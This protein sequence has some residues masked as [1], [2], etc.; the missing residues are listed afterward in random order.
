[1]ILT[2]SRSAT[3]GY[4]APVVKISPHLHA[5]FVEAPSSAQIVTVLWRYTDC[6]FLWSRPQRGRLAASSRGSALLEAFMSTASLSDTDVRVR[7]AV[8]RQLDWDPEVDAGAVGVSAK[9]GAVTLTGYIDTYAGKLAAERAAKRVRGV[10]AVANDIQVRL[11]LERTDA[12]IAAD[13][14]RMLDLRS[15]I[16]NNVQAAVH[17]GHV[18]LT[19]KVDWLFQ[20]REAEKALRHVRGVRDVSNH[21]SVAPRAVER[22]VKHRI[23]EALHRNAN[24]D[25]RHITVALSGD[26]AILTGSVGTWL[27]RESA[28]RAAADAPGIAHVD[29]RIVVN[30]PSLDELTDEI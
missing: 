30:P 2:V 5:S 27:Q 6:L 11:K 10:R 3:V 22:D 19:G 18:T 17:I 15:T 8:M 28:E 20:K 12:D 24:L 16:P 26:N 9:K 29:N 7:D 23:V 1:M 4:F 25:A 21:I 14:V 13:V